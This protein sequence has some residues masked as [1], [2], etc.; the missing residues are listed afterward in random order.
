MGALA[1]AQGCG[2]A[3]ASVGEDGQG[4][5][6][7]LPVGG[8]QVFG[9]LSGGNGL[10]G[11]SLALDLLAWM[12]MLALTGRTRRWEPRRLR[13]RLFSAATQLVTTGRRRHLGFAR[14][15]PWAGTITDAFQ[16]LSALPNP[17]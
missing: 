13:L 17:D 14:H 15:W 4:G 10:L 11:V 12:P 9:G 1:L 2:H 3:A 7:C 8:A 6:D 16:R 5:P